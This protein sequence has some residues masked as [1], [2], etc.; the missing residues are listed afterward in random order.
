MQAKP[1]QMVIAGLL[2][3][4]ALTPA[5][6]TASPHV[7]LHAALTPERLGGGTTIH[8]GFEVARGPELPAPL[9]KV[10]LRLPRHLGIAASGLGLAT[11]TAK[12]LEIIG[13]AGCSTNAV[14]GYGSALVQVP[15]GPEVVQEISRTTIFMAPRQHGHFS[16]LFYSDGEDP[17]AA[18][19]VFPG[20][21]LPASAP[22]GGTLETALPLV[23]TLPDAADAAITRLTSTI[24]PAGIT[25]YEYAR[26]RW[27]PYRPNGILLPKQC[28]H[29][30]F[31][32][33][34][35]FTFADGTHARAVATVACPRRDAHRKARFAGTT[36]TGLP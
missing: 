18:A 12:T 15:F 36:T 5:G 8:F 14:M 1:R 29:R 10:S 30:G 11:C 20:T 2:A 19:L 13:P 28:P 22:Y 33:L 26:G 25:Y 34:A 32:F 4:V 3:C 21:L 17:V 31:P 9:V 16:L 35:D 7:T 24:G 27:I 23:P 6:A